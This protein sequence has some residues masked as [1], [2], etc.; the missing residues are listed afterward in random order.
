MALF[1]LHRSNHGNTY[2]EHISASLCALRIDG[3]V[4]PPDFIR[5][6]P[7]IKVIAYSSAHGGEAL[8]PGRDGK[9]FYFPSHLQRDSRVT[10]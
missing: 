9:C 6:C 2:P 7:R 1:T 8:G 10:G 3:H 5:L 4:I